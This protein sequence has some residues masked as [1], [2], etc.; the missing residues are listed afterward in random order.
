MPRRVVDRL[1]ARLAVQLAPL[2]RE[3]LQ[4]APTA[5]GTPARVCFIFPEGPLQREPLK[6]P[7]EVRLCIAARLVVDR[8]AARLA[9]QLAPPQHH[10]GMVMLL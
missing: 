2:S 4:L 1:A 9:V 5:E 3:P 7:L 8:L 10:P 6:F